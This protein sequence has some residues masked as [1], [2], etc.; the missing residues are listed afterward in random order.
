MHLRTFPI[1]TFA[2]KAALT[3]IFGVL[4][5]GLI[6]SA[7]WSF[8]NAI[9]TQAQHKE[10]AEFTISLAPDDPQTHYALAVLN[11]KTFLPD[12]LERSLAEYQFAAALAPYDYRVWLALAKAFERSGKSEDASKAYR[13]SLEIAPNYSQIHWAFGN[14]LLRQGESENAFREI[15]TAAET[16]SIYLKPAVL[17][18]WQFFDG[19]L[20]KIREIFGRSPAL[21]SMLSVI[22]S[23]AKR[24]DEALEVWNS[25]PETDK[26]D[27]FREDGKLLFRQMIAANKF[28]DA[29]EIH[30]SIADADAEKYEVGKISNG[31]F[32]KNVDPESRQIFDWELGAGLQPQILYD[33]NNKSEGKRSLVLIFN[34]ADGKDFRAISQLLVVKPGD[35]HKLSFS[36]KA[37]LKTNATFRWEIADADGNLI[38]FTEPVEPNSD[39]KTI[40]SDFRVPDGIEAVRIRLA[41]VKCPQG[42]CPVTG[43]IWFDD[44]KLER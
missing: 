11:E 41:R 7:K 5:V 27:R 19:N 32:E 15:K 20:V 44:F 22:L 26:K 3:G 13:K 30:N 1:N 12:D 36:G 39:W 37:E 40:S 38:A 17:A 16:H 42:I 28:R 14:F 18:A 6:F 31:G 33:E 25:I 29:L 24:Y 8:A 9:S 23:E 35:D 4:L 34:S 2:R 21:D 10:V 43:K